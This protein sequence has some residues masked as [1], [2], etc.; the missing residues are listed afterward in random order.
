M[1]GLPGGVNGP[2]GTASAELMVVVG[3]VSLAKSPQLAPAADTT[4]TTA[5]V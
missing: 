5:K 2:A 4:G 1:A 3:S